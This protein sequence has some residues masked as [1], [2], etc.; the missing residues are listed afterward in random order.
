[1]N[2]SLKDELPHQVYSSFV[3]PNQCGKWMLIGM[4]R[5]ALRP[6]LSWVKYVPISS[7]HRHLPVSMSK[8]LVLLK[9]RNIHKS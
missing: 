2:V 9:A 4:S 6:I 7:N 1:M 8:D 5:W 3:R